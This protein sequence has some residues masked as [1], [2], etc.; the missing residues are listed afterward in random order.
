MLLEESE[1]PDPM[2]MAAAQT[3]T[4]SQYRVNFPAREPKVD[5]MAPPYFP[6]SMA[7]V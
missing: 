2:K 1:S 3:R 6:P 5:S 7:I 4:G